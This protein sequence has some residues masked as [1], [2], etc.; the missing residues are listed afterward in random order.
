MRTIELTGRVIKGA[1][2]DWRNFAAA[3]V[4]WQ[5]LARHQDEAAPYLYKEAV[6]VVWDGVTVLEG[7][8]RRCDL[9]Q[10]GTAWRWCMEACDILQPLEG[11]LCFSSSGGLRGALNAAAAG[12]G[13]GVSMPRRVGIASTL[14][15]VLED[16]R[17]HGLLAAEVGIDVSVSA[18]AWM[19]DTALSCDMY[20]SVLRKV[21]ASRPGMVCR[22]DYTGASPVIRVTDGVDLPIAT[23]DR[24][25]DR[26]TSIKLTPRPDLVPPAVG[27]VLTAG[28]QA[29]QSQAWP[30]GADLSQEGCVTV[31]MA[32]SPDN[33]DEEQPASESP[34]WDFTKPVVEV[35]GAKLPTND[36]EGAIYWRRKIPQLATLTAARYGRIKKSVIAGIDGSTQSNYSAEASAQRYEHVSGQLSES[37]KTIKWCYVELKQYIYM[38]AKPPKGCEMLFPHS[39]QV[40]GVTRYYHWLTWRGRT[41]NTNRRKYRVS[42]SGDSGADGGGEPPVSGGGSPPVTQEWPDYSSILQDYYEITRDVPVEGSVKALRPIPPAV[43]VGCRLA[44]TGSRHAYRDM[45]TV[46]QGVSVDLANRSTTVTTGVPAHLSLQDMIDR[47]QQI[48][49][50]QQ[51]LDNDDAQH[52]PGVTLT[53]DSEAYKS[54]AAPTLGPEGEIVWTAAPE[55]PP[56]YGLQVSLTWDDDNANVTGYRMRRGQLMLQGAYIGQTPGDAN[57]WYAVDGI[58]AGEIW[59]DVKFNGKGKLTSTSIAYEQGTVNPLRMQ[60]DAPDE[61]EE[62]SYSFH[63]STIADKQV[64]QHMLGTIQIPVHAGTFYPYGPAV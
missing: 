21:L 30:P 4:S 24:A 18:S 62:Y 3:K 27:V 38:D 54:P 15:A 8:I 64:Y 5:Q 53:Y 11:A 33:E 12:S 19:W 44:I 50:D 57:G 39:K 47:V 22:V 10:D 23:L 32:I 48:A 60:T 17:K 34:V 28:N 52:N 59:L 14:K 55:L 61:G 29:Y 13:D 41:I 37:C 1:K 58:T 49:Q 6:R 16:A 40:N 35:T 63:I 43:L 42:K 31:Q 20:A 7:T 25:R 2:Y 56:I 51:A 46:I 26:L 36:V 45:A 9:E